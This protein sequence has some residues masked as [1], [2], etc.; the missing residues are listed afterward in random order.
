MLTVH[1]PLAVGLHSQQPMTNVKQATSLGDLLRISCARYA[2]KPALMIP[3]KGKYSTLSYSQMYDRV[4]EYAKGLR[5]LELGKGDVICIMGVTSAEWAMTDWAAQTLGITTVPIYPTLPA[6]Q[7]Q[8]IARDCGGKAIFCGAEE[9]AARVREVGAPVHLFADLPELGKAS[10][11]TR[12]AWDEIISTVGPEDIA[13][14]IYTSGTTGEPKGAILPHRCF[15]TLIESVR[16]SLPLGEEDV[17]LSFLPL[18]HVFERFAGHALPIGLG[19]TIAYSG[20]VNTLA[21]DM[22]T[23]RPTVMLLAPRILE[24][25]RGRVLDAVKKQPTWRQRLFELAL[26]QGVA[27]AKGKPAPLAW[28]TD[29][30]V[31]AKVRE[32]TGGRVRLIASG[33]AALAPH[34]AEFYLAFS[35]LV[36]QGYGLTETMAAT[37]INRPENNRYWTVGPPLEGVQ[38][39]IAADGEILIKG[40]S[41]MNGYYNLPEATAEA[42]DPEGWF[43]SGD[44]GELEGEHLK[45]TD[46]K[47]DLL[48]LNNGK[49]VAPQPLENRLRESDLIADAVLF[50]DGMDYCCALIVPDLDK[51]RQQLKS[52]GKSFATDAEMTSSAELRQ[53][54][55][56]EIDAVNSSLADFERVKRFEPLYAPFS[57]ESGELTP[58]LKIRRKI[59]R[60]KYAEQIAAMTRS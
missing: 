21:S 2:D 43:H 26:R 9:Q 60:E 22:V 48:V 5:Q 25:I 4:F 14:L 23:V 16:G 58:T 59:V 15:L 6:D 33:S 1:S 24:A 18:A 52:L 12:E 32:R 45:I 8:Y 3:T 49:N 27:R 30:L 17:F 55:K 53:L 47:K 56:K 37:C 28:L 29:R 35:I 7:A 50:G 41:V 54:L 39:K 44:I 13:T 10:T 40:P 51:V 19:A 57:A 20:G 46:R 42:M 11:L 34:V 38:L 31:G 36:L